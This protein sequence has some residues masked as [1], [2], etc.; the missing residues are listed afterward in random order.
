MIPARG[1][2]LRRKADREPEV[3]AFPRKRE[4][5]RHHTDNGVVGAIERYGLADD[6]SL[7]AKAPLPESM[8]DHYHAPC[9]RLILVGCEHAT[10]LGFDAQ[11]FK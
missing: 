2:R 4:P 1:E 7:A 3:R 11:N 8:T 9:A 10:E 5:L 6:S